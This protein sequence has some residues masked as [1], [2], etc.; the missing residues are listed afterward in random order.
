MQYTIFDTTILNTLL[1]RVALY[2]LK[3]SGWSKQG[4]LPK[5]PKY[6]M[7][8]EIPIEKIRNV[9]GVAQEPISLETPIGEERGSHL[10]DFIEDKGVVSPSD[11][12]IH[13]DI[14]EKTRKILASLTPREEKILRMRFGIGEK[15]DHTLEEVGQVFDVTRERIRQ[16]EAVALRRL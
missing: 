1:H 8:A 5:I 4:R 11:R 3:I 9:L 14:A 6:V 7:I 15:D 10:G 12:L 2:V 16:I 13:I